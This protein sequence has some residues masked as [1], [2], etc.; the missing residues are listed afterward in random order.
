MTKTYY[1]KLKDPRWQKKRLEIME[2]DKFECQ[3]CYNNENELNVHHFEY[4]KNPW[5]VEN[6]SLITLCKD[7]HERIVVMEKL[8]IPLKIKIFRYLS[9]IDEKSYVDAIKDVLSGIEI[10]TVDGPFDPSIE[11]CTDIINIAL[12]HINDILKYNGIQ[13]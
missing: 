1:E 12:R 9:L 3:L 4:S 2:R 8:I 13:I 11:K 10:V 7:C 6:T 5:D